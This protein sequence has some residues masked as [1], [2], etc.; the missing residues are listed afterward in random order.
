MFDVKKEKEKIYIVFQ[1]NENLTHNFSKTP[2]T[3]RVKA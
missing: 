3:L 2:M 1:S